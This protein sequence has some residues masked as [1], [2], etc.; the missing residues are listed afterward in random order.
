MK[1]KKELG[2]CSYLIWVVVIFFSKSIKL[3]YIYFE[4]VNILILVKK[5]DFM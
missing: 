5:K 3:R 4:V 1:Y 2:Y